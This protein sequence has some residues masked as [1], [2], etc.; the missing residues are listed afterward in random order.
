MGRFR[1]PANKPKRV[2]GSE[3][4]RQTVSETSS[5]PDPYQAPPRPSNRLLRQSVNAQ[6]LNSNLLEPLLDIGAVRVVGPETESDAEPGAAPNG[7]P[8]TPLGNSGV[9]EGPPSVS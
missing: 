3:T 6:T 9:T 2:T 4:P 7:G 5:Y 8:A 1:L